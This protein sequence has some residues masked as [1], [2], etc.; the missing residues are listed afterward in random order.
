MTLEL[1][2]LAPY[3]PY[4]LYFNRLEHECID[5]STNPV[6]YSRE[7]YPVKTQLNFVTLNGFNY[8]ENKPLLRRKTYLHNLQSEMLIRWGGVLSDRAKAQW[9]KEVT[10][11]ML[12]SAFNSLR[13]DF[14]E[15]MLE[16]HIDVFGLIDAGLATELS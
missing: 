10:D 11:D 6:T 14:V 9:L 7:K 4:N 15:L 13:Y 1:K 5:K 16:N 3:L 12:Y 8:K 2:H